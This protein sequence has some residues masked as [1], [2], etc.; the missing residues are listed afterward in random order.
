MLEERRTGD[1][2]GIAPREA[3]SRRRAAGFTLVELIIVIA[4]IGILATIAVPAMRTAPIRAK[5]SALK[6]N[7]FTLRSCIDQFHADRGRYP[8]SLD[9]LVSMGYVRRLPNDPVC[10][11][12][13]VEVPQ[14]TSEDQDERQQEAGAG[15]IDVHSGCG[16]TALDGSSYA[17]W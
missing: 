8:T 14:D 15:I 12:P 6:E 16:G 2:T 5:E 17:D 4:I 10:G 7:L 11:E 13:W 1:G 3:P 9:E